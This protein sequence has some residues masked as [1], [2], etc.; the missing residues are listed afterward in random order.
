[1]LFFPLTP[2]SLSL[3][4][5]EGRRL[6]RSVLVVGLACLDG[7]P[8]RSFTLGVPQSVI[9]RFMRA[10]QSFSHAEFAI[11]HRLRGAA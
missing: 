5:S 8:K 7:H 2:S 6:R 9:A 3:T 4:G 10:I 11:A 1:M